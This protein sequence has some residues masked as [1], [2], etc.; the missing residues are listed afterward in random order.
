MRT[1][2]A[3]M[4]NRNRGMVYLLGSDDVRILHLHFERKPEF[5]GE[6]THWTQRTAGHQDTS[7]LIERGGS[8]CGN[9]RKQAK[10]PALLG[11]GTY[12]AID[13]QTY[14]SILQ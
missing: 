5:V 14:L 10:Q 11:W 6:G 4:C 3:Q 1:N 8:F 12:L 13:G 2:C 9:E 7:N